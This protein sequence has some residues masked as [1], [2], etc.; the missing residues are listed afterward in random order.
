M[1]AVITFPE[2]RRV[3]RA[4]PTQGADATVIILPVVRIERE[5]ELPSDTGADPG[6]SSSGGKRRRRASRP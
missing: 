5:D 6:K 3:L 1:G 4:S 2:G